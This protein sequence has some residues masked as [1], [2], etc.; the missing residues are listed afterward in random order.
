[1]ELIVCPSPIE[2]GAS[3]SKLNT[4]P[5]PLSDIKSG[6]P[7]KTYIYVYECVRYVY[8]CVCVVCVCV[9]GMGISLHTSGRINKY[10]S[11]RFHSKKIYRP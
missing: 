3:Y 8:V 10:L 6:I 11:C 4:K 1:M 5:A 2:D 9:C 7:V